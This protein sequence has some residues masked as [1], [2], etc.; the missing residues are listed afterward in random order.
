[1]RLWEYHPGGG[2]R[3]GTGAHRRAPHR[4][5][6]A[7]RAHAVEPEGERHAII[8]ERSDLDA[9]P[10]DDEERGVDFEGWRVVDDGRL[11]FLLLVILLPK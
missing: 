2:A 11:L 7:R 10:L 5:G 9:R 4:T 1:M 3:L 6:S 8:D